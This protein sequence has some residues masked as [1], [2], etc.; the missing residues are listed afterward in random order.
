MKE[1]K[2]YLYLPYSVGVSDTPV[3]SAVSIKSLADYSE[4]YYGYG[5]ADATLYE[6]EL[7]EDGTCTI[8]EEYD[9]PVS[10][11]IFNEE[12]NAWKNITGMIADSIE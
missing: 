8:D 3:Y 2:Y 4:D 9:E 7:N 1:K 5:Y 12:T 11:S 10:Y 6:K